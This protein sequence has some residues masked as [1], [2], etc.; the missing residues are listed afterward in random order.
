MAFP[1][2]GREVDPPGGG[3]AKIENSSRRHPRKSA[4]K[5][6]LVVR[7]VLARKWGGLFWATSLEKIIGGVTAI[8]WAVNRREFV[9]LVGAACNRWQVGPERLLRWEKAAR[10]ALR[11][12]R[13]LRDVS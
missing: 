11:V 12:F 6:F 10:G 3:R 2:G 4:L 7:E 8:V 13:S 5:L 9:T 1:A